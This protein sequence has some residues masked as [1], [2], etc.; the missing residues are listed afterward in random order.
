MSKHLLTFHLQENCT[1]FHLVL[2]P[3]EMFRELSV[4]AYLQ[5]GSKVN[6]IKI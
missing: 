1:R 5:A 3:V 4:V 6:M 2:R